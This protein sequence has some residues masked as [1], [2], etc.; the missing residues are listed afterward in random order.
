[1]TKRVYTALHFREL[2]A[3]HIKIKLELWKDFL[4][5]HAQWR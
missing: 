3:M 4:E 2:R 5:V 1:M